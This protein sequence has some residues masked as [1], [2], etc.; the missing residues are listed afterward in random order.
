M[1]RGKAVSHRFSVGLVACALALA[2]LP[3][4]AHDRTPHGVLMEETA[5]VT[6]SD[7]SYT[8]PLPSTLGGAW[9]LVDHTG[10]PVTDQTYRGKW[11]LVFFGYTGCRETC[12]GAL[13]TMQQALETMGKEAD[14]IQPLFIDF[15]M[16]EPDYLGL[17]Q[18]VSNFHPRLIG[19]T[20]DRKQ[21]F[22]A[23]RKFKVRRDYSM[24]NYSSKETGPRINHTTYL[25]VIDPDGLTRGYFS[26][27][28][29]AESYVKELRFHMANYDAEKH[30]G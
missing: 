18:F 10:H 17:K 7:Q 29:P 24:M 15:S 30:G 9:D 11:M 22:A 6:P 3:V 5:T 2:A 28:L 20:G 13:V 16:E 14:R 19:L 21:T 8:P 25:F 4:S 12:P 26:E 27:K 1:N 23:V